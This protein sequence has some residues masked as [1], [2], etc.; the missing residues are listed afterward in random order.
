M[1]KTCDH[2]DPNYEHPG[3]KVCWLYAHDASYR[4]LFD[5]IGT[6]EQPRKRFVPKALQCI[7][8]GEATG[9]TRPC[10]AC[11]GTVAVPLYACAKF[12][13]CALDK[14]VKLEDGTS[15]ACC[16]ICRHREVEK[17]T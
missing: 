4:E 12:G 10:T 6:A 15:V 8:R 13:A 17:A 5:A 7:H 3:C 9:Q 1:P 11:G 16:N 14:L 2:P